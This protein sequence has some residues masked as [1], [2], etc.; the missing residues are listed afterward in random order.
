MNNQMRERNLK[1]FDSSL[2]PLF[3]LVRFTVAIVKPLR[4]IHDAVFALTPPCELEKNISFLRHVHY[5]I[6]PGPPIYARDSLF[7]SFSFS[8]WRLC[9]LFF[10]SLP[11][12]SFEKRGRREGG[13]VNRCALFTFARRRL[14]SDESLHE[15]NFF[16][17]TERILLS[18][19]L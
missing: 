13:G 1:K 6:T 17:H 3:F 2:P 18:T 4:N 8:K 16:T 19:T 10:T 5:A 12:I 7:S 14:V 11:R 15:I 9:F